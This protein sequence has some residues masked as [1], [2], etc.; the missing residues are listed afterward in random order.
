MII[1]LSIAI[2]AGKGGEKE[3]HLYF[4]EVKGREQIQEEKRRRETERD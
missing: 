2:T 1:I 3:K 4:L